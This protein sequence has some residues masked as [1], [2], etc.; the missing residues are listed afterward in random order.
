MKLSFALAGLLVAGFCSTLS[1]ATIC[2]AT[3]NTNTDCG[4]IITIGSNGSISGAPVTGANPYDGNDDSLIGVVNNSPTAFSGSVTLIGSGNGGGLFAL[5]GDGICGY[6]PSTNSV[7][8]SYCSGLSGGD[9]FDYQGPLN[10]FTSINGSGT[11]GT[12]VFNGLAPGASTFFSLEG[13]PASINPV[14]TPEPGTYA[15]L[16]S[17]VAGL[18]FF[19]RRKLS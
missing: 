15:L 19:R 7:S 16:A 6:A 4:Y 10:T 11:T 9:P 5:D 8:L 14:F 2:P 1:A 12:V 3:S 18:Y 13:S 17:G